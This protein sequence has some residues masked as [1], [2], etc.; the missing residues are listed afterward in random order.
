MDAKR[1]R[2]VLLKMRDLGVLLVGPKNRLEFAND[3]ARELLGCQGAGTLESRWVEIAACVDAAT[4]GDRG[5]PSQAGLKLPGDE[6]ARRLWCERYPLADPSGSV[7]L[8]CRV[9]GPDAVENELGLAIQ[10]RG[11]SVAY[12]AFAHD[13]RAPLN[14][15]VMNLELLKES[16]QRATSSDS[17]SA[18][19]QKRYVDALKADVGRLDRFLT[20]LVNQGAL[21]N[22]PSVTFDW[23]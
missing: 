18:E 12:R 20:T 2:D 15:M 11:V 4:E 3:R 13:M 6:G 10:M 21:R 22:D 9:G 5:H 23:R 17:K 19:R 16:L 7:V 8:L 14:A 1:S